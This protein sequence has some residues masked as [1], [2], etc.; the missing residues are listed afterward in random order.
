[1][2]SRLTPFALL[3]LPV[4]G[5]LALA[6]CASTAP[7]GPAEDGALS[8]VASTNVYGQ[9]AEQIGG[10]FVD[11]TAIIT[12]SA[13]DPH[14]YEASARDQ[15]R[16]KNAD[17]IIENG[18]GYDPFLDRL[19]EASDST[20]PVVTAVEFS[21]DFP[22]SDDHDHGDGHDH[23]DEG[24]D[25][26]HGDDHG[27]DHDHADEGDDHDQGDDHAGHNHIAGFN[28][29]VWYDPHT[30]EH[31]AEAVAAELSDLL[32]EHEATFTANLATFS[33]GIAELEA[34][35]A[36][37]DADY[38]GTDVFATEP[39][40]GYLF[41]AAGLHDVTPSAFSQA[42]E[43][44][45]DVPP[46]TLLESERL[47]RSGDVRVVIV[48]AQTAG[49]ETTAV[50]TEAE[51]MSIPVLEFTETLPDDETYLSWMQGNIEQLADALAS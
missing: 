19:I 13:Q 37:L 50:I 16:V 47:L 20:A 34:S 48:N 31:L 39:L 46:A 44:G 32:P 10:E 51:N 38:A 11:V 40:A 26:D 6:G 21:H 41:A 18:G 3:A 28:E 7:A 45:Q 4:A 30:I 33:E 42:V 17:L 1:M 2:R 23:G 15:L 12:S 27:D 43:E 29:H 8:V 9:I 24:D 14:S 35:L 36:A 5:A 49:A 25:H 22:G